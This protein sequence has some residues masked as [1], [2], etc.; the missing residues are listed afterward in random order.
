[1]GRGDRDGGS[2]P[3]P[4]WPGLAAALL[5]GFVYL[6]V[7]SAGTFRFRQS[8][9]P[10]HVLI[11]DAWLHGQL[12]VREEVVA[13]RTER[14]YRQFR[15]QLQR[16][17]ASRG[18]ALTEEMWDSVTARVGPG[19]QLDWAE[20][21]GRRYGY[22]GPMAA[23][24]LLPWVAVA[25]IDASDMLF[26]CIVGAIDVLLT[27]LL[28]REAARARLI[29]LTTPGAAALAVLLGL[30]TVHFYLSVS[31]QVWFVTQVL[32]TFFLT[33]AAWLVLR[34]DRGSGWSTAAGCA[35][36]A[37]LLA[38]LSIAATAPFFLGAILI[39]TRRDHFARRL[40]GFGLPLAVA[41]LVVLAFNEA[42]FGDPFDTGQGLAVTKGGNPA[43][44]SEFERF[45]RYSLHHV[46]RNLYYYFLN[47]SLRRHPLSQEVTF[48]PH[49]NSLFLV[50]PAFLCVFASLRRCSRFLLAT[51]LA[52]GLSLS[53]LMLLYAT[54]W[55]QFGNRYV[56]DCLPMLILLVA[57]GMRGRLSVASAALIAASIA[58]NSWGTYRFLQEQFF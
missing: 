13:E 58:V 14:F 9:F 31:G 17:L 50:T 42:R 18:M 25:G 47:P 36:A 34:S 28:L 40:V 22:W 30:G 57:A 24:A 2:S 8:P 54:G 19:P 10:H 39:Q 53:G 27:Y 41:A 15:A 20:F 23:A 46:P 45:G 56:L 37:S 21:E 49:G 4:I 52:V 12:H 32:A 3:L 11:A 33:L 6:S 48:D 51:W 1:M 16:D 29:E 38:R 44:G 7:A 5:V 43:L 35:L 55:Y 26:G